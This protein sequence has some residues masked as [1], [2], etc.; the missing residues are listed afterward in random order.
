MSCRYLAA[1]FELRAAL[2]GGSW[3]HAPTAAWCDAVLRAL[4][5]ITGDALFSRKMRGSNV[6]IESTGDKKI[7][8]FARHSREN[9]T[10]CVGVEKGGKRGY[11]NDILDAIVHQAH[12]ALTDEMRKLGAVEQHSAKPSIAPPSPPPAWP[13]PRLTALADFAGDAYGSANE[14]LSFS[15]GDVIW[16]S[17]APSGVPSCGWA[18]GH[19]P[20]GPHGWY[21]PSFVS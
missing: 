20:D 9:N 10:V 19:L 17:R 11:G 8:L 4:K 21:P 12:I 1:N 5:E 18:Y 14:Y 2:F 3:D 15:K 7:T 16:P 6:Y 13:T